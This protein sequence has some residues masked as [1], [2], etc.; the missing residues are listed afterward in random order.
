MNTRNYDPNVSLNSGPIFNFNANSSFTNQQ[1]LLSEQNSMKQQQIMPQI[2]PQVPQAKQQPIFGDFDP[3][4]AA[5]LP[6]NKITVPE[7]TFVIDSRQRDCSKYPSPSYYKLNLGE[8]YKNITSIE[9]K[10]SIIPRSSYNVHS[11]NKFIDFSIGSTVTEIKILNGGSGYTVAPTV[12]IAAPAPPGSQATATAFTNGNSL[13]SIVV[14]VPGSGYSTSDPPVVKLIGPYK[15]AAQ[16]K[17]YVGTLYTAELRPGQYIIG[18][19]PTPPSTE[20]SGLIAEIQ[21]SM[22]YAVTG[23]YSSTSTT[24]FE[25]R[26]VSQYPALDPTAGS[27]ESFDTNACRYNRIQITNVESDYWELLMCSGENRRRNA[28]NLMGYLSLDYIGDVNTSAIITGSGTLMSAG[29]SVRGDADFD[30]LDD[31]KYVL[32][33][34]YCGD[35]SFDRIESKDSS[36][37]NTFGTM[38]FDANTPDVMTDLSGSNY[39][40]GG[41]SYLVGNVTKGT[42]WCNPGMLKAL[43]GFDFDRKFLEFAPPIG[44]LNEITII[45]TQFG[46]QPGGEP[47]LYDFGGRN[48]FLIFSVKASDNKSGQKW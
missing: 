47:E 38:V 46:K 2:T 15:Q 30:L 41:V 31:P 28:A 32:L 43:R 36:L 45:F 4:Y 48:H 23:T 13:T 11:T 42:F 6:F 18:G 35:N 33:T 37:D 3:A 9:L 20:P 22:N 34:F 10:G 27:P 7:H 1:P 16:L 29:T 21:N 39:T 24:P 5:T 19:N 40:T 25:V 26:L 17:V 12:V 44:K 14:T 8:V